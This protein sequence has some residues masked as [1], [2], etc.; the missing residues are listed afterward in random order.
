MKK[1]ALLI[2]YTVL[3]LVWL[4]YMNACAR[5]GQSGDSAKAV[6]KYFQALAQKD[7]VGMINASCSAWEAQARQEFSSFGAVTV[8]L[9]DVQCTALDEASGK[10]QVKCEGQII[11]N[12]GAE[13]LVIDLA[14]RTY[15]AIEEGGEWRMCGY[16]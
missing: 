15:L 4:G 12:Y 9:K 14:E 16:Q 10:A 5:G 6:I 11:A 1:I 13:D 8:S 2:T 7:E 3:G